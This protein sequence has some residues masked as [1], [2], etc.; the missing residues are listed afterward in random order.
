MAAALAEAEKAAARG[1][2]PIG[3]VLINNEGVLLAAAGNSPIGDNDPTAHAEILVL[4]RAGAIVG[5]YRLTGTTLYVTLEPCIMCAGALIQ[6]RIK[7]LVFGASDPKAGAIVS[8]YQVGTDRRMNHGLEVSG[9]VEAEKCAFL[10]K[11]FF[12]KRR[13][14]GRQDVAR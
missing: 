6:A 1:E 2:V 3:A 10:L 4:R 5:N 8:R 12:R 9:G 13:A 11:N 14:A 7:R